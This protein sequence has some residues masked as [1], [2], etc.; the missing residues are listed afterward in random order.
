[1]SRSKSSTRWLR[2]HFNDEYV[3]RAQ[4]AG[5]RSRA[6]YKL[7][8]IQ[9]KDHLFRPGMTVV[10]LG[11]APGGWSQFAVQMIGDQGTVVALDILPMDA[12]A[13]VEFVQGDFREQEVLDH[14][15]NVLAGR[16]VDLVVSDMAPTISGIK[17]VDQPRG[18][19]LSE[20]ALD[21][22]RQVL[23]PGGHLLIKA[24]QGEG[25]DALLRELRTDFASAVSRKP[26]ASRSRSPEI[27]L[28]AR[29]YQV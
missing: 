15:L 13:G 28:L 20:L 7:K 6:V 11:A 12:L 1:M 14:L 17:A 23:K 26:R 24:F 19:Y 5:Y 8:E 3:K 27:Y 18:I 4:Q 10:D 25:F 2:E 9:E 16:P 21:F 29:N 22:A